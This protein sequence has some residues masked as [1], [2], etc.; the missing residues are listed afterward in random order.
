[1]SVSIK[2]VAEGLCCLAFSLGATMAMI[3]LLGR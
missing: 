2:D 3:G 1:M